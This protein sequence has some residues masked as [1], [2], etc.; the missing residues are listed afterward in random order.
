MLASMSL[1]LQYHENMDAHTIIMHLK[2][3]FDKAS[4]IERYDTSKELFHC[5]MIEGF[6]INT[7]VLK[8]IGYIKKLNQLGFIMDHELSVHLVLQSI[9]QKFSQFIMN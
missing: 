6:L 5:K 4:K 7:D 3:L 8:I 1:E 2:E 9:N